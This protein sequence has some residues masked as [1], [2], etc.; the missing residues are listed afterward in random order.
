M[1][2]LK[3]LSM[4]P[5]PDTSNSHLLA[6]EQGFQP[7]HIA[8]HRLAQSERRPHHMKRHELDWSGSPTTVRHLRMARERMSSYCVTL[9]SWL[10]Q[11]LD[12]LHDVLPEHTIH[13]PKRVYTT[14][15]PSCGS[16]ITWHQ[17]IANHRSLEN[18]FVSYSSHSRCIPMKR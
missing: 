4:I 6:F 15:Q 5:I 18:W 14:Q 17:T 11:T 1:G 2:N 9:V 16:G 13:Q 7:Q 3:L 10:F 12:F 8:N